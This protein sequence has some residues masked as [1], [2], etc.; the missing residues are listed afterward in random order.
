MVAQKLNFNSW[1]NFGKRTCRV[2]YT[3]HENENKND[4]NM[5]DFNIDCEASHETFSNEDNEIRMKVWK[6]ELERC[7]STFKT[8]SKSI[9]EHKK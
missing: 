9:E 5:G 4:I 1:S 6:R 8:K 3:L 7:F 2:Q